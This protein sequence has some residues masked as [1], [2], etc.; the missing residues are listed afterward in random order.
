MRPISL[1]TSGAVHLGTDHAA[2][3]RR[4]ARHGDLWTEPGMGH[5][6]T[7]LSPALVHRIVD[8]ARR[9]TGAATGGQDGEAT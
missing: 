2:T 4:V 5:G 8:W 1:M 6:A 3:L 7:G 9:T